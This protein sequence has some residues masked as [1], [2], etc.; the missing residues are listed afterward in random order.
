MHTAVTLLSHH[1]YLGSVGLF[2]QV[3]ALARKAYSDGEELPETF[4]VEG[5]EDIVGG[6]VAFEN[7]SSSLLRS[8]SKRD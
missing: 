4:T 8:E 2:L 6:F 3:I 7:S 1:S 5:F